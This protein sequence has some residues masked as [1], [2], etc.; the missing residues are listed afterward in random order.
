M[1]RASPALLARALLR[2]LTPALVALLLPRVASAATPAPAPLVLISLDGFRWD[3]LAQHPDATPHLRRLAREGVTAKALIP[4][5]PSN[6]FPNHH[7]IATGLY[8]SRHGM[9]NN[10]MFDARTEKFFRYTRIVDARDGQWWGGEP[11]WVTAEKQGRVGASSFWP[12]AEAEIGGVRPTIVRPF[13]SAAST[14]LTPRMEEVMGWLKLPPPQRPAV[15]AFYLDAPNGPGHLHGPDSPEVVAVLKLADAALGE[16]LARFAAEGI[17]ANF[18]IVSDHG[19][20]ACDADRVILLDDFL[21]L[22]TIQIDFDETVVGLR[23]RP[24]QTVDAIMRALAKLPPT[25]KAFRAADLPPRLHLDPKNPRVPPVWIVPAEGWV[26]LKR[27]LFNTVK[28]K[29]LK[30]Q[31]GYDPAVPT[32]RGLFI[33]HGPAFKRGVELEPFENVHIYNLLCAALA[34]K[35]APNDGDDRLVK[36]ALL[37]P[38]AP[39]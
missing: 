9:L 36:S 14:R 21:D 12:G 10:V 15:V 16:A 6:T 30:G 7:S 31:H 19:M 3:Y 18:V 23:P 24:G 8:P 4:V 38:R 25:A 29:F 34:L 2:A 35:P 1:N 26:V 5:F 37:T 28:T 20:T 11:I 32:M 39:H 27:S 22:E 17:A 33:A 13:E